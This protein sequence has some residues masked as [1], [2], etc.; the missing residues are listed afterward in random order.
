MNLMVNEFYFTLGKYFVN[1]LWK[2][3]RIGTEFGRSGMPKMG[4]QRHKHKVRSERQ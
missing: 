3:V 4:K 2:F 1:Y